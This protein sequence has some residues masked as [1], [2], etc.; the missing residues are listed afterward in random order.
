[1]LLSSKKA[2]C[3]LPC[4]ACSASANFSRPSSMCCSLI[5]SSLQSS[6]IVLVG[7]W[8]MFLHEFLVPDT[9]WARDIFRWLV[10]RLVPLP[11]G[12]WN[13]LPCSNC[14]WARLFP[15]PKTTSCTSA[16]QEL[17]PTTFL[18]RPVVTSLRC[19]PSFQLRHHF[20]LSSCARLPPANLPKVPESSCLLPRR[21]PF[22]LYSLHH[23]LW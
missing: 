5:Q 13:H 3:K 23:L 2:S 4:V 9:L 16:R 1:M 8:H 6:A 10:Y 11:L 17:S 7:K 15:V 20:N 21:A 19:Q 18:P 14:H 22:G 12:T